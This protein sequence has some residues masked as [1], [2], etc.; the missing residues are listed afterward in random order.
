MCRTQL[1]SSPS[2]ITYYSILL[3]RFLESQSRQKF[4]S[5]SG[6][7]YYSIHM[8]LR[9]S[10]K[11][12]G[13]FVPFGD[14]VLLNTISNALSL[15]RGYRFRPLRG[16]RITQSDIF[17]HCPTGGITRFRPLRGSRITQSAREILSLARN[18]SF[19][20]PSGITYY[21]M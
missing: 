7:T 11:T 17:Q 6:I 10:G 16:S 1:F 3:D 20:S 21:S 8:T 5:P 4:S 14:H 2:G 15:K 19:S 9:K 18:L 12:S 13:V